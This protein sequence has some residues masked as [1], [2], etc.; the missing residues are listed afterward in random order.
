MGEPRKNA[1]FVLPATVAILLLC[2]LALNYNVRA[3]S[4]IPT[5]SASHEEDVVRQFFALDDYGKFM[6]GCAATLTII[7]DQWR[8]QNKDNADKKIKI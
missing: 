8:P 3:Q 7:S 1:D 6:V 2:S 4:I 5:W